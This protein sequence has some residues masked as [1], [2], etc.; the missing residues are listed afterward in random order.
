[1]FKICRNISPTIVRQL[2]QLQN[3]DYSLPYKKCFLWNTKHFISWPE[4]QTVP[5]EF[6]KETSLDAFKQLTKKWQHQNQP[7]R[8]C[9]SYIQNFGF[10]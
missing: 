4:N 10:I 7:C 2:F 3:N 1:M 5:N 9:K 8:L 6:K